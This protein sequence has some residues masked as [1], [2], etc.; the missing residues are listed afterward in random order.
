[1][2][3]LKETGIH[4]CLSVYSSFFHHLRVYYEVLETGSLDNAIQEFSLATPSWYMSHHTMINKNGERMRDFVGLCFNCSVVFYILGAFL[5]KQL[6]HSRLL[7][8]G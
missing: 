4:R 8:M 5:I 3:K 6:F 2:T 7:D 1:M